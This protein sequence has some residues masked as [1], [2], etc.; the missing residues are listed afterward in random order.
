MIHV[1]TCTAVVVKLLAWVLRI[2]H[3]LQLHQTCKHLIRNLPVGGLL[4]YLVRRKVADIVVG[5][6]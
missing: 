6:R 1:R 4:W 3:V 2:Q 5:R